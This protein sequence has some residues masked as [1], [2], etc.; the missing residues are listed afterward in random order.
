MCIDII[1]IDD[2]EKLREKVEEALSV[3]DEYVKSS[4]DALPE[5]ESKA[6]DANT[7]PEAEATHA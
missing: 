3:Y 2:D 5:N 6:Q 1:R 7:G 4:P